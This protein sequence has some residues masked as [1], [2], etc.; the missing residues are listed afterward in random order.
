MDEKQFNDV[1]GDLDMIIRLLALNLVK[2]KRSQTEKI[3]QL[4]SSGFA[5]VEIS[6]ILKTTRNVVS[7]TLNEAK[8]RRQKKKGK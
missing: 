8:K 7:V 5:P 3:L 2:D 1:I 6:E 4:S